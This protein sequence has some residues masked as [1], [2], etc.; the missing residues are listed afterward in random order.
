[1]RRTAADRT[2]C[3]EMELFETVPC[4]L[5]G[6]PEH[7]QVR[8]IRDLRSNSSD[9]YSLVRCS[10]CRHVFVNPRPKQEEILRYYPDDYGPHHNLHAPPDDTS[11]EIDHSRSPWYLSRSVRAI[12][13]L[14]RLYYWLTDSRDVVVPS[15]PQS[16][17]RRPRLLEL[18]CSDGDYLLKLAG[19][20][21]E[22]TGIE[23]AEAPASRARQR[24]LDVTCGVLEPGAYDESSFDVVCAWHVIEHLH[25]PRD[26]VAEVARIL[27]PGGELLLSLPNFGCWEQRFFGE[28]WYANEPPIHLQHFT[29]KSLRSLL[30][31]QGFDDIQIGY[32]PNLSYVVG[33]VGL[34]LRAKQWFPRLAERLLQFPDHPT[35]AGQLILAFPAK[36]LAACRQGG[37]MTVRARRRSE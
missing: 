30:A 31:A 37:R 33:S 29:S 7:R 32:Q 15:F 8:R 27:K 12:P 3:V 11:A 26:V 34:W 23:P 35:L 9:A 14:R 16:G 20:G 1:M 36:F 22:T 18:G 2:H 5:C 21:W 6:S 24:G 10:N 28:Y 25:Q 4:P 19:L 17:N 13:G